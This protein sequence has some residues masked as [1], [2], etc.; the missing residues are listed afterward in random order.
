MIVRYTS[1]FFKRIKKQDVRIRN[2][3]KEAIKLF[4]KDPNTPELNNHELEREWIGFRSIDV[5]SDWRA[6]F[7]EVEEGE[8]RVAYFM[9]V[10]THDELYG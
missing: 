3:F 4:A 2:S 10:G 7:K 5:T 8:D 6:I 9:A 1:S